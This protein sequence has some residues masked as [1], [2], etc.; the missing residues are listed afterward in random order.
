MNGRINALP[1]FPRKENYL[2]NL[3]REIIMSSEK[4]SGRVFKSTL[5]SREK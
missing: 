2:F 3:Q 5:V 4:V 1:S